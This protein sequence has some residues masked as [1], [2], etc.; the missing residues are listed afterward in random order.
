MLEAV[1]SH[2]LWIWNAYFGVPRANDGLNV[3]YG[4]S[5]FDDL[6]ADIASEAPF[7][8]NGK[9]YEKVTI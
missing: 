3:L 4:L 1:A 7:V 8:V 6:I 9:T 5:L 2:D